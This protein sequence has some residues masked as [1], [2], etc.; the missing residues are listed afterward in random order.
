MIM[1][2]NRGSHSQGGYVLVVE[3]D[4]SL[5]DVV[6]DVLQDEGYSTYAASNG[7]EALTHIKRER[8]ELVL[9][10]LMMPLMDGWE[11]ASALRSDPEWSDIPIVVMTADHDAERKRRELGAEAALPKPFDIEELSELVAGHITRHRSY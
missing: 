9:L 7:L 3:D 11:L 2:E 10:D 8:P 6:V 5:C 1:H 4:Q